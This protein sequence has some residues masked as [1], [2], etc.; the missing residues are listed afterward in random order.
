MFFFLYNNVINVLEF[1]RIFF[2]V[3]FIF[4]II[5]YGLINVI[6]IS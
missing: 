5:L 2:N 6:L 4:N 1:E 3:Y